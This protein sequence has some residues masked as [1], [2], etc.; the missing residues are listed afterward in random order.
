MKKISSVISLSLLVLFLLVNPVNVYSESVE[1]QQ[2]I[3]SPILIPAKP[4][5]KVWEYYWKN[6]YYNK[7]N[8]TKSSN[9][10][11]VWSYQ[12]VSDAGKKEMIDNVKEFYNLETSIKYQNY[13]HNLYLDEI[14]CKKKL[15]RLKEIMH[16]DNKGNV[17]NS[18]KFNNNKDWKS[19]PRETI[20]EVLYNKVC[21]KPNKPL[22][23]K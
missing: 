15:T 5:S 7:N 13:D 11:S 8:M 1:S 2:N 6:L 4:D 22:K 21:V 23:K 17:L 9:I 14:D 3:E 12:I 10:I 19:I 16:Y 20:L 18:H